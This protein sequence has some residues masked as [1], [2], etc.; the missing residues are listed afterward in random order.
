MEL[1]GIAA[2]IGLV[3]LAPSIPVVRDVAKLAVKGGFVMTDKT[4]S[5]VIATAKHWS[6]LAG[7][8]G[9]KLAWA[10]RSVTAEVPIEMAATDVPTTE[11][12]AEAA[13]VA[14]GLAEPVS[15]AAGTAPQPASMSA[16]PD[17]LTRI[18]GIGPKMAGLLHKA[19]IQTLAQLAE[20]EAAV[21]Q[22]IVDEAG[23]RYRLAD[24]TTWP[25][26]AKELINPAQ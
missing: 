10:P 1:L 14:V 22:E 3:V 6:D 4:R 23:S 7:L 15:A 24:P 16:R 9:T 2:G 12:A 11:T 20:T 26:Q 8:A 17:D 18:K 13:A 5:V 21:L 19:G 25:S